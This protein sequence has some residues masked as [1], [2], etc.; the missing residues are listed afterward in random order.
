MSELHNKTIG[1]IAEIMI[2]AYSHATPKVV[3]GF[4]LVPGLKEK[5]STIAMLAMVRCTEL[6]SHAANTNQH[7]LIEAAI[8]IAN[9]CSSNWHQDEKALERVVGK[10]NE[11]LDEYLTEW[12]KRLDPFIEKRW[13]KMDEMSRRMLLS[14]PLYSEGEHVVYGFLY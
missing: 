13:E 14:S 3:D 8:D 2:R 1:V 10:F 6:I 4:S 5:P 9:G 11:V 12:R 7:R